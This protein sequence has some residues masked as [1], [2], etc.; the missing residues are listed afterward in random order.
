[1]NEGI[2]PLLQSGRM[3]RQDLRNLLCDPA[4]LLAVHR[5]VY[6]VEE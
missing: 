2:L 4:A 6:Q 3:T 1:M 5:A